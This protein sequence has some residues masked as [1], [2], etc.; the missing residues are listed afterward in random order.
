[1]KIRTFLKGFS[2][3][4]I[5][6]IVF[7]CI[8]IA[9]GIK[10]GD[11]IQL[12]MPSHDYDYV[13]ENGLKNGDHIKGDIYYNV[14][15]FASQSTYTQYE[16]HRSGSK[17][18]GYY[19]IIPVGESGYAAI[20]VRNDDKSTMDKLED[21]TYEY[22]NGGE[23]PKSVL[24]FNGVAT[25]MEKHLKGLE[26]LF[27]DQ[28]KEWE[29]TDAEIE[30]ML[31]DT[32]GEFLVLEGPADATVVFIMEGIGV[33]LAV[34]GIFFFIRRYKKEKAWEEKREEEWTKI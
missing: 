19:Y 20:Y 1:M 12:M 3:L 8:I 25:K 4:S 14:G 34:L 32:D 11:I 6:L 18:S 24:H 15:G 17:T 31:A 16:D 28:L 27:K 23:A 10:E 30:E 5:I 7:G 29:F 9:A 21:E 2:P 33:V 26:K 22:M 13:L